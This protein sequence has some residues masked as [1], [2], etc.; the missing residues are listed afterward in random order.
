MMMVIYRWLLYNKL[1]SMF[2]P[3]I[4]Y[5]Y[6]ENVT[7][8]IYSSVEHM[9]R[10][11]YQFNQSVDN[12]DYP[13][14]DGMVHH[15]CCLHITS[16]AIIIHCIVIGLPSPVLMTVKALDN[17]HQAKGCVYSLQHSF[18]ALMRSMVVDDII[19]HR[20]K[21]GVNTYMLTPD[22]L[23]PL[24]SSSTTLQDFFRHV[25]WITIEFDIQHLVLTSPSSSS[26]VVVVSHDLVISHDVM[27]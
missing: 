11:Y 17:L 12:F 10:T 9:V 1:L 7:M 22:D 2:P 18:A 26:L 4:L 16:L 8:D 6:V 5:C 3:T 25:Q 14:H 13:T 27:S 20:L 19:V 15:S 23:G 21:K 24:S